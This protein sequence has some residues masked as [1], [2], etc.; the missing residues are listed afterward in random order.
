MDTEQLSKIAIQALDDLKAVDIGVIDVRGKLDITDIM[1]VACGTSNRHVKALAN[2]VIVESKEKGVPPL[3]VEGEREAE[4]ILIDLGDVVVHVMLPSVRE[5]YGL[6]RLWSVD[7]EASELNSAL[8][9]S[10]DA[11]STDKH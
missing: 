1:I 11:T 2:N 9:A 4:W 3:G 10:A 8:D 5:F 6:E 7:T